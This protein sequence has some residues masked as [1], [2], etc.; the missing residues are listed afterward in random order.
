MG[1]HHNNVTALV[2]KTLPQ[3]PPPGRAGHVQL[4]YRAAQKRHIYLVA[5]GAPV[6]EEAVA[7][8]AKLCEEAGL[9]P[10]EILPL[11]QE[12]PVEKCDVVIVFVPVWVDVTAAGAG[13]Q[14]RMG[15]HIIPGEVARVDMGEFLKHAEASLGEES[16]ILRPGLKLAR[17]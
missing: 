7:A 11:G 4:E 6:N 13:Q 5:P 1:D 3:F 14:P 10:Q 8:H 15:A 2:A 12:L 17:G 16:R 9:P